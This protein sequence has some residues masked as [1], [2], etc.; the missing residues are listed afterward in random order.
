VITEV[1][2]QARAEEIEMSRDIPFDDIFLG[3]EL[4]PVEIPVNEKIV[5]DYCD[6]FGDHNAIYLNDAPFGGPL[7]PPLFHATLHDLR[8]LGTK[9]DTHATVPSKTQHELINP[10]RIG[11]S[12]SA[13]GEI[14]DKYIK[15]GMEYVVVQSVIV[16]GN[17]LDIRRCVDHV[18]L[19]LE[20]T[21]RADTNSASAISQWTVNQAKSE[22]GTEIPSVVKTAYQRSLHERNFLPDSSHNEEYARSIGYP[23]R[24]VSG[25]VLCAYMSEMLVNLFGQGWLKGGKF[26]A[27]FISPGVQEGDVVT[28]R[29]I[30]TDEVKEKAGKRVSLSI[31][32]EKGGQPKV[33]VG[34]ASGVR[35]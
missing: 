6:E 31:W 16:D 25:Y 28:C 10:A 5:R 3:Q 18:L 35:S 7:V 21:S 20:R 8:L 17:G 14:I 29:G 30:I 24:L 13:T 19:S 9:W 12:L 22:G 1:G 4:G 26:S 27:S 32:M 33:V 23:G 11:N 2:L 15:R 34:K